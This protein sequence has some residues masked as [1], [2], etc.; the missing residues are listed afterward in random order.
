MLCFQADR[1][2]KGHETAVRLEILAGRVIPLYLHTLIECRSLLHIIFSWCM[3][4]STKLAD[5]NH[6]SLNHFANSDSIRVQNAQHTL[7]WPWHVGGDN[8]YARSKDF[9][10]K[11]APSFESHL[12][13]FSA[14]DRHRLLPW[15]GACQSG[16]QS[17]KS[18]GIG[19][20][21]GSIK[22]QW[23]KKG[24]NG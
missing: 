24:E 21:K 11:F 8:H 5:Q 4:A 19:R 1:P 2:S 7:T 22:K 9:Y 3:F 16:C 13:F 10:R 23:S 17:K 12:E 6:L 18:R 20:M 15:T 14:E